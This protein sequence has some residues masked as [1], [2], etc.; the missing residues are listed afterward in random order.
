MRTKF[1]FGIILMSSSIVSDAFGQCSTAPII[2]D[3]SPKTGFIGSS[4][5]IFGANFDASN[6]AN[7]IVYFG[8]TKAQVSSASFGQLVVIV[9]VGAS[10]E[11]ISVTNQCKLTAYSHVP[12]NGIFCP[13]PLTAQTYQNVA[14]NLPVSVGAYNMAAVDLDLDGKADVISS[15]TG[16]GITVAKNNSVP[17][18]L[19]FSNL[20]FNVNSR[21]LYLADLDGDGKKDVMGQSY[22]HLNTSTVGTISF[23]PGVYNSGVSSYQIAA[24]DFNNDGKLDAVGEKGGWLYVARN[25]STGPGNLSFA[26]AQSIQGGISSSTGIQ[27]ADLD[28][29]G[30]VDIIMSQ[31]SSNRAITFRNT[32]P[33]GS[34]T[35]SFEPFEVWGIGGFYPY[36]C[37]IADFNKDGKMDFTTCNFQSSSTAVLTNTSV[38]GN[39]I[40]S[41][42]LV[43]SAFSS[44]YRIQVGDVDGDGY[45]DIVTK[46]LGVNQFAVYKNTT[47]G[48]S[49]IQFADPIYYSSSAQAEVSGIVIG[50]LDGDYV[51]DIATSGISS[52]RILFHRN[53]SA[54]VD[55]DPPTAICKDI[56]LPLSPNGTAN[57]T[58]SM[59]NNGSSDACGLASI[60]ASKTSFDCNDIGANQVTLTVTDLAGNTSS[61]VATVNVQPAAIIASGQTTVCQGQTVSLS[62]NLGDSYQWL[63]NGVNIPSAT[64]QQYTVVETGNYTVVVTNALGCSGVSLPTSVLVNSNP[65]VDIAPSGTVYL[66]GGSRTLTASQSSIYQW[67]LN[68]SNISGSTQQTFIASAPG[69]YSVQVVDLFGCQATSPVVSVLSGS[70]QIG[71]AGLS[72]G[73]A[74]A[75]GDDTPSV[76]D[77]TD[78]G[79]LLPNQSYTRTFV[80]SNSGSTSMDFSSIHLSGPDAG[81]AFSIAGLSAP[82]TIAAGQSVSFDVIFSSVAIRTYSA[83]VH[84]ISNSCSNDAYSFD[85]SSEIQCDPASISGGPGML[86]LA[87]DSSCQAKAD[88]VVSVS[89][90]PAPVVSYSFSGATVGSGSGTGSGSLFAVGST[91]VTIQVSNDCG[92]DQEVIE[93]V[94]SD[95]TMP[96]AICAPVT[97]ALDEFGAASIDAFAIDAGS[98]DEC[99]IASIQAS[100]LQFDCSNVGNNI[101]TLTVVDV[102]GN[103]SQCDATVTVQDLIMPIISAVPADIEVCGQQSVSWAP[104]SASDN[105]LVS[106]VSSH[107]SGDVFP[108]GSTEVIYTAIDAGGNQVTASFDIVVR[109][110]PEPVIA[111]TMLPQFCQGLTVL[112]TQVPNEGNLLA[113]LSYSWSAGLGSE[114]DATIITNGTYSVTVTDGYGC[115]S[116]ATSVVNVNAAS[117]LSAYTL[118][119]DYEIHMDD[120]Y[121]HGGGVGVTGVNKKAKIKKNSIVNGFVQA[122]HIDLDPSSSITGAAVQDP[123]SIVLPA[124]YPYVA[125]CK[126]PKVK[127]NDNASMTLSGDNYDQ[128]EVGKNATL[129]FTQADIYLAGLKLKE[130]AKVFFAPGANVMVDKHVDLDKSSTLSGSGVTFYCNY[131]VDV[132]ENSTVNLNIYAQKDIHVHGKVGKP[133]TMTGLFIS[134]RKIH[135]HDIVHWYAGKS[136]GATVTPNGP[137]DCLSRS[138][139]A[140]N[141]NNEEGSENASLSQEA[142]IRQNTD[143]KLYPNP[144]MQEQAQLTIEFEAAMEGAGEVLVLDVTGKEMARFE[145]VFVQ[146]S[147][148]EQIELPNLS[149]GI[150]ILRVVNDTQIGIQ[151]FEV[152]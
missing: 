10:T 8:A 83:K 132:Q 92:V 27:T 142:G 22:V 117:T 34:T 111:Q 127:V 144:I 107:Q 135:S 121:V 147:N 67:K 143:V 14:Q 133:T 131:N 129:T 58:P 43:K 145:R 81:S 60:S 31:G 9:P 33:D 101:V 105:C 64:S 7:N 24:G 149:R 86:A 130:G 38:P 108:V 39:I 5:S 62:A 68:G 74:I 16:S 2:N 53:T 148:T 72:S 138:A 61:C 4:V 112:K 96:S 12:F 29:D 25:L 140:F 99:G 106:F 49:I 65:T 3:F 1:L 35:F 57:L 28:G 80:I 15:G 76:A 89:G 114:A 51:P 152:K 66:C 48:N 84:V 78:F 150:Y 93:I 151:R 26:N 141:N 94:V 21:S 47:S 44:N 122:D 85:L 123:A 119:S 42:L 19:N 90:S 139:I 52:N 69:S 54:Q 73:V 45:A 59:I 82:G 95:Q 88:Y 110:L 103:S 87:T 126:G 128:V 134:M 18:T 30:K 40:M 118:I 109:S 6:L 125:A 75:N 32:T 20:Y 79:Q 36:R 98:S 17:G 71:I 77:D 124:F 23:G 137:E 46:S 136:C 146:G 37:Q 97:I 104:A 100:K 11:R 70:P 113:P 41:T 116:T 102:H 120:S 56:V 91:T 50:D 63:L 55:I 13:T 115:V